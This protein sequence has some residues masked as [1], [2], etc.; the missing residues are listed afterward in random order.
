MN[1]TMK[2]TSF[3]IA[4]VQGLQKIYA[5]IVLNLTH[6]R[7]DR[8]HGNAGVSLKSHADDIKVP[9]FEC[10]DKIIAHVQLESTAAP[11]AVAPNVV[12]TV[13]RSPNLDASQPFSSHEVNVENVGDLSRYFQA[14]GNGSELHP[15]IKEKLVHSAW[16]HIYAAI[17]YA[18]QANK[19]SAGMHINIANSTC[20][21]LAH[22][23]DAEQYQEFVAE[24]EK[25][26]NALLANFDYRDEVDA[27]SRK[28][29]QKALD[30]IVE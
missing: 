29:E 11:A 1:A 5:R 4:Y 6:S 7:M 23:M 15:G 16:D 26:L 30:S 28:T 22:Y 18:N 12:G 17:R 14:R 3:Y 21:E 10:V 25:H 19:S 13:T 24:I 2:N 9:L 27:T 20:H 8:H